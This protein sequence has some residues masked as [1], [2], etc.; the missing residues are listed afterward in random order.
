MIL[1]IPIR[2]E[3]RVSQNSGSSETAP[4]L[5]SEA[6]RQVLTATRRAMEALE[7][8]W[9]P[10]LVE[11]WTDHI[12]STRGRVVLTGV[13]KSGLI[14]QK[15]SATMAST[16]CPSFYVHPTDALHGDLG[17]I[18]AQDSV[19]ILSNSGE[20]EEII[21]LLPSLIRLGVGLA[22]I[23]ARRDSR[24]GQAAT[25]CF[26]YDL[27]EGEGCPLNFAPMAS[28]TLQL[29]WGDLL[30][31]FLM[32][33][34]GFTLERFAQLHPAGNI[35]ARLLKTSD[36]MHTDFPKVSSSATLVDALGSMTVGRLGMTTVL[37]GDR[38]LGIISDGDIRRALERAQL[39]GV[40]PLDLKAAEIMT[41]KPVSVDV[42]TLAV[43]A[44]RILEARKI[45]FLLVQD[46]DRPV[47]ILHIH[48]LL[49]AKV[50]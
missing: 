35:G 25:W 32:V 27:P 42:R 33:K 43:E 38:L 30:A 46:G 19:L 37:E 16:G 23:T 18:T 13:G 26:S 8:T 1:R 49:G 47:G 20:T 7:A 50:I 22:A 48:D 41:P 36:L 6:A 39:T 34:T 45:T 14:A 11:A 17:M 24:L 28:T 40:N 10:L 12:G 4:R 5:P 44:A 3:G 31:A 9:D 21:K 29:V 2:V 15:I